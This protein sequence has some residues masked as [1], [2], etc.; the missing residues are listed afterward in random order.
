MEQPLS[1]GQ[2]VGAAGPDRFPGVPGRVGCRKPERLCEPGLAVGA[3]VGQRLAGPLAGHQDPAPGIAQVL[4]P[5]GLALAGSWPQARPGVLRLDAVPQPVRAG[6]RAWLIPQRP[7]QAL[8]VGG[9]GVAVFMVAVAEVLGQVLGEVADAPAG[10]SR[11][12]QHSFSIE[13]G[14]EPGHVQRLVLVADGVE[15]LVPGGEHLAGARV[16]VGPGVLVP[17]RQ[18]AAVVLDDFGGWPPDLVVGGGD[19]LAGFGSGDGAAEGD[20]DVRGE[21]FLEFDG[22]EVLQVEAGVAAQMPRTAGVLVTLSPRSTNR[23]R[24]C[25]LDRLQGPQHL[26]VQGSRAGRGAEQTRIEPEPSLSANP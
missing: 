8:S 3:V 15:G 24:S 26:G 13:P 2:V 14:A 10:I 12:G 20:V 16:E 17:D 7:G 23:W 1:G 18:A 25:Q 9:L 5:V 11:S 4:P 19:D 6:R 21:P 22:G